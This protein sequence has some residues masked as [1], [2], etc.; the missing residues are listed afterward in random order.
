MMSTK[1]KVKLKDPETTFY[2][3]ETKLKVTRDQEVELGPKKGRFTIAA[4]NA[5]GLIEVGTK[6]KA[7]E[8]SDESEK[9][10]A[11]GKETGK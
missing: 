4:L 1:T 3:P 9:S 7:A 5:G 11:K 2:D 8:K 10:A 6:S